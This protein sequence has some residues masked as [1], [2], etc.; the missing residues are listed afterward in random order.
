[1]T[2]RNLELFCEKFEQM[3]VRRPR[4]WSCSYSYLEKV[5]VGAHYLIPGCPGLNLHPEDY[6]SYILTYITRHS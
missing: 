2:L 4:H 5:A 1:V 3:L 6:P